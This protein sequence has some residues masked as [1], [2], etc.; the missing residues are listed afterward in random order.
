M[1]NILRKYLLEYYQANQIDDIFN[2]SPILNQIGTK[3]Q[4]TKYI[5]TIFPNSKIKDIMYH[6][7]PNKFDKFKDPAS[8][9]LSHIWFSQKPLTYQYGGI[10]YPVKLN[11]QNPISETDPNF[12]QEMKNYEA[13]INPDWV[14]NYNT[15]GELPKFK[16]DATIRK[17]RVSDGNDVTV[18][19]PNQI[20]IL[21]SQN[22]IQGFKNYV[23]NNS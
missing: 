23:A 10:I 8:S 9:G 3:E 21:G 2:Q 1:K 14:N 13:P 18:R 7:S 17:S 12:N 6:V 19:N 4:Y 16:Y 11:I 5:D 15:T 20:H 22:D